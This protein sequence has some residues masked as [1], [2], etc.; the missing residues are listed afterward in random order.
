M[1]YR[2]EV[3]SAVSDYLRGL[4]GFT[5]NGRLT[6]HGFLHV[7]REYGDE[8]R[9][10]A[11]GQSLLPLMAMRLARPAAIVDINRIAP[12]AYIE[13][14]ADGGLA[15][16][17]LT[18]QRALERSELVRQQNPL[19]S[20]IIPH[21]GHFQI[22]NRGTVGGSAAHADPSA[23]LPA[24]AVAMGAEMVISR[25]SGQRTM[26]AADFFITYFA[27]AIEPDELL[28][29]VRVPALKPRWRWG[30]EEVCRRQGDA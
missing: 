8:A 7:L 18:R 5:R 14:S 15:I 20:S 29:E 23:E 4:E 10:L 11:G 28:T 22:R 12:L 30:F 13:P 26:A 21:I 9:V 1:S 6:M 16:G 27:T 19:L 3:Q 24:F 17:A 25:A 2:V